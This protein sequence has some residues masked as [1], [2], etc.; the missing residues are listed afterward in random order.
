M[1][2]DSVLHLLPCIIKQTFSADLKIVWYWYINQT[3]WWKENVFLKS[4]NYDIENTMFYVIV[5]IRR[6]VETPLTNLLRH[7]VV[8]PIQHLCA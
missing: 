8:Y 5:L 2:F 7:L 4:L 1:C 3:D 6:E